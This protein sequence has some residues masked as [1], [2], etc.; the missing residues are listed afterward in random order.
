MA[1]TVSVGVGEARALITVASPTG[2]TEQWLA[3]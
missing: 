2:C 1:S 3:A